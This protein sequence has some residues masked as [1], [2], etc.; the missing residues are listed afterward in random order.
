MPMK[1][2]GPGIGRSSA[3]LRIAEYRAIYGQAALNRYALR[4]VPPIHIIVKNGNVTLEGAVATEGDRNMAGLQA[5]GVPGV[6]S[7]SNQLR[8]EP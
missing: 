8:I 6:F 3:S 7:V 2:R 4:A 5:N 1:Q